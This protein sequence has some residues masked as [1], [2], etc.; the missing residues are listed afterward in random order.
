MYEQNES[1]NV[2]SFHLTVTNPI[3]KKNLYIP[4]IA[5]FGTKG[6]VGKTTVVDKFSSL[7]SRSEENP[8]I[9]MVD[10]DV[11]HRGLT[12]LRTR[13]RFA[14]CRTV[15]EYLVDDQLEFEGAQDVTPSDGVV[16]KGKEFLMPSSNLAAEHVFDALAG[17]KSDALVKRLASLLIAATEQYAINLILID[18]G[19]IVD[20][21]TASAAYMSDMAFIIGQ[22]EPITFQSLQ[23][24][25]IRIRDFL[26]DFNASKVLV[27]LNK[28][29]GPIIQKTGIFAAI[30]FTMEVVDYSEGLPNIDEVRLVFLDFC[31]YG[32][33]KQIFS[34]NHKHLVP[35]PE[36]ILTHSQKVIIDTIE[37]YSTSK[38]YGRLV[39]L[40]VLIYI[41]TGLSSLALVAYIMNNISKPFNLPDRFWISNT[42]VI[43]LAVHG[44]LLL[45][46]GLYFLNRLRK[47][48]RI[49]R[50]KQ[51]GGIEM[52]LDL[53]TTLAGRQKFE[54][55]RKYSERTNKE[56]SK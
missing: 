3:T 48:D 17:I 16:S 18:C 22:N 2:G 52:V 26:P 56:A 27:I 29:R 50:L 1:G 49:I 14:R 34:S 24:Y 12:V 13:D 19:P 44:I 33:I 47:A 20:P 40:K 45:G 32:I 21:L 42:F 4:I 43:V 54:E 25:A 28:V 51:K 41:G 36:A 9:L 15:H 38:W 7:V 55:I 6:G 53:L 11:H 10:F 23:N 35:N 5:F 8:N 37:E 46:F 31:I 39:K 30:P